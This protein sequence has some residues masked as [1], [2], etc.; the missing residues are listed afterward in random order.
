MTAPAPS[1]CPPA[2]ALEQAI[3]A[4]P[5]PAPLSLHVDA[6]AACGELARQ[7]R[8]NLAFMAGLRGVFDGDASLDTAQPQPLPADDLLPNYHILREAGRGAQGVLYEAVQL[9]TK[10]RVAVKLVDPGVGSGSGARRFGREAELAASLRHPNIIT[11]Y[12]S[13]AL[14]D[15]RLALVM[16]YVDGI[17]LDLWCQRIDAQSPPSAEASRRAIRTKLAVISAVCAGVHYAHANGVIH[18]DLKPANILIAADGT[19]RV[20]DFGIAR[21]IAADTHITRAGGFVGTLAYASPEQ[22][23]GVTEMVDTRSDVYALGLLLYVALTGRLPYDTGSSLSRTIAS[24]TLQEPAPLGRIGPGDRP[25]GGELQA[26]VSK[27]LAKDPDLRYQSAAALRADIENWLAGRAVEAR[28][29]SSLYV[30]RKLAARHRT[31]V[32]V[33]TGVLLLLAAFAGSTAWSAHRFSVQQALLAD[34]LTQGTIERGRAATTAGEQL[35]AE[36]LLW[37]QVLASAADLTSPGLLFASPSRAMQAAWAVTELSS[38][39]PSVAYL[40]TIPN[41]EALIM[42]RGGTAVRVVAGDGAQRLYSIPDGRLLQSR[43]AILAQPSTNVWVGSGGRR[44]VMSRPR[45]AVILELDAGTNREIDDER[46]VGQTVV[47]V[48][49]DGSR[50]LTVSGDWRIRLWNTEPLGLVAELTGQSSVRAY[51][52]FGDH[53][54]VVV[55][56]VGRDACVWNSQDGAL[57]LTRQVPEAIMASAARLGIFAT[58]LTDDRR[59]LAVAFHDQLLLFD[60]TSDAPEPAR[61]LSAHTGFVAQVEFSAS[62]R[63]LLTGG[64]E[65]VF[66]LWE[67]ATGQLLGSFEHGGLMRTTPAFSA[68]GGIVAAYDSQGAIRVFEH[69]PRQWFTS[70]PGFSATVHS[71]RFSPDGRTVA[72]ASADGTL[73]L[74]DVATRANVWSTPPA[75]VSFEALGFS[76]SGT[77][78]AVA[79]ADGVVRVFSAASAP[80]PPARVLGSALPLPTWVGY[81]PDGTS[82]VVLGSGSEFAVLRASDG[83][84]LRRVPAHA[85]RSIDGAFS[86]DGQT[87]YVAGSDGCCIAY[88]TADWSE[89]FRTPPTGWPARAVAVSADGTVIAVGSDDWKIRL[90]DARSGALLRTFSSVRQHVF[91][92][93]FHRGGNVLISCSRSAEVQ[94]WDTR[95]GDELARLTGHKDLVLSMALA[96]D[97]ITLATGSSDRSA[98]LWKLDYYRPHLVGNAP[99]WRS[100]ADAPSPR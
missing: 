33:A 74:T 71:V 55:G 57:I 15:G 2:D 36:A 29:Q 66:R 70:L 8:E 90:H 54:K 73:R 51:P 41:A 14:S 19:P 67:T 48:S 5:L 59:T 96:P 63:L 95:T 61:V 80:P 81:T 86:P 43:P 93:A 60:L 65:R 49:A 77:D 24:I 76:P 23:S 34:S 20:V 38:R 12:H 28:T 56:S 89:R 87:F 84:L 94:L 92:L 47:D 82:I 13:I 46:L 35:R 88:R 4:G 26:I 78:I 69:K 62:G 16:E 58:R 21:R 79:S 37:P 3:V 22:V 17:N 31:T 11:V 68:D 50:L 75:G 53:G 1:P 64:S 30:L 91:G 25:A 40:S 18:R 100:V 52:T 9:D 85:Q 98:A 44:A 10:R 83:Q 42:E 99:Y 7:I 39:F 6:C 27:A 32:I 97:G 72:A 45:G